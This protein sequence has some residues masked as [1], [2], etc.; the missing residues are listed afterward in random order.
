MKSVQDIRAGKFRVPELKKLDINVETT[1]APSTATAADN[2][3][4]CPF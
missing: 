1:A 3:D 4:D 2:Y